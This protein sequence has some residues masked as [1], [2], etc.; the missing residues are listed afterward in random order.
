MRSFVNT[1]LTYLSAHMQYEITYSWEARLSARDLQR[2][3]SEALPT[4]EQSR[5]DRHPAAEPVDPDE[6]TAAE[7]ADLA[8]SMIRD[9]VLPPPTSSSR[10]SV[11]MPPPP[12]VEPLPTPPGWT[13]LTTSRSPSS[14]DVLF[15]R[16]A[17][18]RL[19]ISSHGNVQDIAYRLAAVLSHGPKGLEHSICDDAANL[20]RGRDALMAAG[21]NHLVPSTLSSAVGL[22]CQMCSLP[23]HSARPLSSWIRPPSRKGAPPVPT[24]GPLIP[25]PW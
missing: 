9:I 22:H 6:P 5:P 3:R 18:Q 15:V 4:P 20:Q 19:H 21:S 14:S 2:I 13:T 16:T 17:L 24:T 23:H 11:A 12:G 1:P 7:L 8:A 10:L 25:C